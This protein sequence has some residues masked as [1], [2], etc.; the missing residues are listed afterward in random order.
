MAP[1]RDLPEMPAT[2]Q[3]IRE[4]FHEEFRQRAIMWVRDNLALLPELS[5]LAIIPIWD[6]QQEHLPPG[7]MMGRNGKLATPVE[8][9]HM[10]QALH[11]VLNGLMRGSYE[12]LQAWD[13]RLSNM[14]EEIRAKT[15]E[16]HRLNADIEQAA[17]ERPGSDGAAPGG[18]G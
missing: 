18:P 3:A 2:P 5:G 13:G 1:N 17:R 4:T 6:V 11:Q 10:A 14:A 8:V 9:Y 7:I 16:L 15:E 12:I